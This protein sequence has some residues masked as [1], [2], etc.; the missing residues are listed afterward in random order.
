MEYRIKQRVRYSEVAAN[1][2]VNLSQIVNYFQD[3]STFQ[4]EDIGLG[5]HYL[6][7]KQRAWLL[8]GWQIIVDRYPAFGEEISVGTW[9]Y[10]WKGI[11]GYRNFDIQDS[12]GQRIAYANSIWVY[13]DT[14]THSP[15]KIDE[16][17]V[18]HYGSEPRIPMD[19]APRKIRMP[20]EF[21]STDAFPIM[22]SHIDTNHHVNNAKYIDLAEEYLP[23]GFVIRQVRAEYKHSAVLHDMIYPRITIAGHTCTVCL[24][25]ETGV[26]YVIVEFQ[27]KE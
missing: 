27:E 3:C 6:D 9:A 19:Y 26:P 12:H 7:Q 22:K 23:D 15:A 10:D 17:E 25:S 2:K 13:T 8:L 4:S 1:E 20:K 21:Q 18:L 24:C 11:Y 16:E 5:L 14:K